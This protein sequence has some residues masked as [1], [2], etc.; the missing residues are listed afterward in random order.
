MKTMSAADL[1]KAKGR[2][3]T[4]VTKRPG[5]NKP[6]KAAP[7]PDMKKELAALD[8]KLAGQIGELLTQQRAGQ[9]ALAEVLQEMNGAMNKEQPARL[10]DG[11][12][13]DRDA[14]GRIKKLTVV[15]K[16]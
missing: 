5:K 15:Y 4:V 12:D 9:F 10:I 16:N 14:N 6:A 8:D 3:A 13:V 2:G 1:D 7:A 11:F